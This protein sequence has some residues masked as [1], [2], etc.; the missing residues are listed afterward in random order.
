MT[1]LMIVVYFT[2][3]EGLL[4]LEFADLAAC[5]KSTTSKRWV[6]KSVGR[7]CLRNSLFC[8]QN[9]SETDAR[10]QPAIPASRYDCL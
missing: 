8:P 4:G 2:A 7:D 5:G 9:F 1:H 10:V 3:Q 6:A